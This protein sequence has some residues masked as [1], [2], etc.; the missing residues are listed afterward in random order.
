MKINEI[1]IGQAYNV[2]N[3]GYSIVIDIGQYNEVTN[4]EFTR[5]IEWNGQT[6]TTGSSWYYTDVN[7]KVRRVVVITLSAYGDGFS[8]LYVVSAAHIIDELTDDAV[9]RHFVAEE[10]NRVL[11]DT[12]TQHNQRT[13]EYQKSLR[14]ALSSITGVGEENMS[15]QQRDNPWLLLT[16][17]DI[18]PQMTILWLEY[19]RQRGE[20]IN[21]VPDIESL[22]DGLKDSFRGL[23]SLKSA[24]NAN[25]LSLETTTREAVD[26]RWKSSAAAPVVIATP[27]A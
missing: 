4:K 13:E 14:V 8:R 25:V 20:S 15:W 24:E 23:R 12:R 10:V 5:K 6:F 3:K 1:K 22:A 2:R 7:V 11:L 19:K 9:K 17:S 16:E 18:L 21:G 26:S 27:R